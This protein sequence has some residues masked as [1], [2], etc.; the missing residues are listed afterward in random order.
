MNGLPVAASRSVSNHTS[1]KTGTKLPF[2]TRPDHRW[3][4]PIRTG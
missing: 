4:M 2:A 3:E 1:T